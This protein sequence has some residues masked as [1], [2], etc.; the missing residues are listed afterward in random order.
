[1][2]TGIFGVKVLTG[3][4]TV[5]GANLRPSQVIHWVHASYV[6]AVPV[7]RTHQETCLQ[8]LSDKRS[9]GLRSMGQLSPLYA[10]LWLRGGDDPS[11]LQT[12]RTFDIVCTVVQPARGT[13]DSLCSY[14]HLT[15]TLSGD[16]FRNWYLRR[17]GIRSSQVW[18]HWRTRIRVSL[19]SYAAPSRRGNRL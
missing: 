15:I 10:Q 7:I 4:I 19:S 6:H 5:Q 18:F 11:S 16:S 13:T 3:H 12:G 1:M 14:F 8:L 2:V 17:S 9:D